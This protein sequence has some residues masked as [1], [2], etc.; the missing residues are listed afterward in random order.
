MDVLHS[1]IF[2]PRGLQ[3]ETKETRVNGHF[4]SNEEFRIGNLLLLWSLNL[5]TFLPYYLRSTN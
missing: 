3:S 2:R 1:V 4:S 5:Y